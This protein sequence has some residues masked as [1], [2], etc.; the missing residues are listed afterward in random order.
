MGTD[1][2]DITTPAYNRNLK[3]LFLLMVEYNKEFKNY[4]ICMDTVSKAGSV[5][6]RIMGYI[7]WALV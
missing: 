7:P 3:M 2:F 1:D 5:A 4:I 6:K